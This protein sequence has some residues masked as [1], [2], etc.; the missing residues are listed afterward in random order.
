[1]VSPPPRPPKKERKKQLFH[2]SHLTFL[3]QNYKK[4][5]KKQLYSL[6]MLSQKYYGLQNFLMHQN[7]S[8]ILITTQLATEFENGL[9]RMTSFWECRMDTNDFN[10]NK[11]SHVSTNNQQWTLRLQAGPRTTHEHDYSNPRGKM[12]MLSIILSVHVSS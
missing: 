3:N 2:A 1:M 9:T 6:M 12:F 7:Q 8:N 4:E 11:H 10:H 5:K